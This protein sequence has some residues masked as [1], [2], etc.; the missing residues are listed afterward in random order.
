M[1]ETIAVTNQWEQEGHMKGILHIDMTLQCL[2]KKQRIS[3]STLP[4]FYF[5]NFYTI[6]QQL[7]TILR[8]VTAYCNL[9]FTKFSWILGERGTDVNIKRA[10]W[11]QYIGALQCKWCKCWRHSHHSVEVLEDNELTEG[12]GNSIYRC[13]S[14]TEATAQTSSF[15]P[16]LS[17]RQC[18]LSPCAEC[19]ARDAPLLYDLKNVKTSRLL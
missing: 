2:Q 18:L 14:V 19:Q 12:Y 9:N 3:T 16:I 7:E 17:E 4:V 13:S 5:S 8:I 11:P 15:A 10:K 6:A 1:P